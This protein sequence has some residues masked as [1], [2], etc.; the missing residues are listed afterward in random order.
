MEG[1]V[2]V[3]IPFVGDL[4]DDCKGK[5]LSLDF[6]IKNDKSVGFIT[7]GEIVGKM[8]CI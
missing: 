5:F 8:C 4:N 3:Y 2:F 1:I 7:G 6:E